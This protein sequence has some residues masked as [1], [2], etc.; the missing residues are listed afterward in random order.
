[1]SAAPLATVVP[2]AFR[3]RAITPPSKDSSALAGDSIFSEAAGSLRR[4]AVAGAIFSDFP[5]RA[6]EAIW[7]EPAE[8]A[9][10]LIAADDCV[11]TL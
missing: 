4:E 6:G 8:F 10:A 5:D 7:A 11:T 2:A 1:M 9:G 3:T